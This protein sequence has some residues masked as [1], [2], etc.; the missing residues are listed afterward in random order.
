MLDT[1]VVGVVVQL[2]I[3]LFKQ[4]RIAMFM[5]EPWKLLLKIEKQ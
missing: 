2:E 5:W 4:W 3:G 1:V